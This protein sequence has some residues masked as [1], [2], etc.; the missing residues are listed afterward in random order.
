MISKKYTIKKKKI[1]KNILYLKDL[2][3]FKYKLSN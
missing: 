3:K 2:D 1:K